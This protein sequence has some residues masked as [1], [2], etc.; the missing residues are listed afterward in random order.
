MA[1]KQLSSVSGHRNLHILKS[2]DPQLAV[3]KGLVMDR[4]ETYEHRQSFILSQCCRANYGIICSREYN[5]RKHKGLPVK[6]EP[7]RWQIGHPITNSEPIVHKFFR[8]FERDKPV[9]P[10][11]WY[12]EVVKSDGESPPDRLTDRVEHVWEIP[13]EFSQRDIDRFA[14]LSK[15]RWWS[16]GK[17]KHFRVDYEAKIFF[18]PADISIEIW[19][20]GRNYSESRPIEV[21]FEQA[22][23]QAPVALGS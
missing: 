13:V 16:R 6:K 1:R 21:E 11:K 20:N 23:D 8:Y 5:K 12:D 4:I 10:L 9:I 22:S 17:K 19:Q 2:D 3:A 18:G 14:W 15:D 7:I